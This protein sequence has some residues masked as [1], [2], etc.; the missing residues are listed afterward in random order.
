MAV[1]TRSAGE[2][3]QI[4]VRNLS[5]GMSDG[6]GVEA[7]ARI[8]KGVRSQVAVATSSVSDL[9]AY[10]AETAP[11]Y[12]APPSNGAAGHSSERHAVSAQAGKHDRPNLS[13]AY[14]EPGTEMEREI[15]A[16]WEEMFGIH[17]VGIN[18]DFFELGG[19]S[20]L[21]VQL[22][23]RLRDQFAV[24]APV[25]I[26]FD[27]TTI[28]ELASAIARQLDAMRGGPANGNGQAT[29]ALL[30]LVEGLS[31]EEL[32]NILER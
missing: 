4:R 19:H 8:L 13:T 11:V 23:A 12:G 14:V 15:V 27:N 17:P 10:L 3:E 24:D 18:D 28:G 26:L 2:L 25:R 30:D 1:K 32:Q 16:L 9:Y 5:R 21:A 22:I 6:E 31:P 20:L 29:E 7:F